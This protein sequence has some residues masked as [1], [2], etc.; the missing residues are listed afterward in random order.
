MGLVERRRGHGQHRRGG[1]LCRQ[2]Q[3]WRRRAT[4]SA[5]SAGIS[6]S[7][8]L[9]VTVVGYAYVVNTGSNTVSQYLIGSTGALAALATATVATGD[10]PSGM[11]VDARGRYAYVA[12]TVDST[13]SQYSIGT[14]GALS[15]L[16]AATVALAAA[17]NPV[18]VA[19]DPTGTYAYV[20]NVGDSSIAQ[21]T[22][23][24]NGALSPMT[25]A[26]VTLATGA[27]PSAFAIDASGQHLYVANRNNDT[28]A[29]FAIGTG[30]ALAPLDP[31]HG[32]P[33]RQPERPGDQ[34]E[35]RQLVLR[36]L[37]R[38]TAS[39]SSAPPPMATCTSCRAEAS[40]AAGDQ[41][42]RHG[43]S[44]LTA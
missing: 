8:S 34:P 23:G 7:A 12:N 14:D 37:R 19:I 27:A 18:A 13:V 32:I 24:T 36:C 29:N 17:A 20:A 35:R 15:P 28:I 30:G 4:I 11:G 38:P 16:S 43:G 41:P 33:R 5:A 31:G 6:G 42:V 21:F 10:G 26:T 39:R 44:R 3:R 40:V 9:R 1:Q 2:A 22:I 25:P